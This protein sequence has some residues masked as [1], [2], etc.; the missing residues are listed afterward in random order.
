VIKPMEDRL[1]GHGHGERKTLTLTVTDPFSLELIEPRLREAGLEVMGLRL[2]HGEYAGESTVEVSCGAATAAAVLR[3]AAEL[4]GIEG[5]REV[6]VE[7][8]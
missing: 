6:L 3:L 2:R 5:V 4:Q 7:G 1:L 8:R